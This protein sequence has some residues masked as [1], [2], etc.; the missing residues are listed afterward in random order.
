ME[1]GGGFVPVPRRE[2]A[3]FSGVGPR[4]SGCARC[5]R[6]W[7][8]WGGSSP[9]APGKSAWRPVVTDTEP[10]SCRKLQAAPPVGEALNLLN[11]KLIY[12]RWRDARVT[13]SGWFVLI[14]IL[15][16]EREWVVHFSPSVT[17]GTEW[18]LLYLL[19]RLRRWLCAHFSPEWLSHW[20]SKW[21]RNSE[22]GKT[23]VL[24]VHLYHRGTE[25]LLFV[26]LHR[27]PFNCLQ[28]QS[29]LSSCPKRGPAQAC[30]F[31]F[32]SGGHLGHWVPET[33]I[34][35]IYFLGLYQDLELI[36]F[37][38]LNYSWCCQ[39]FAAV[40]ATYLKWPTGFRFLLHQ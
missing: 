17:S 22:S 28:K 14:V 34:E 4:G 15:L 16:V 23:G 40:S 6:G 11:L 18:Q 26:S 29:S 39:Y 24:G 30:L 10:R 27:S 7:G 2:S 1:G 9:S 3:P 20:D 33:L 25:R 36:C 38:I 31:V 37:S 5:Q 32:Y 21:L 19:F 13:F 8:A 12:N 35:F